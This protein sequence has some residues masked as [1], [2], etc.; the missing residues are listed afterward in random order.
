[1]Q[2]LLTNIVSA[3]KKSYKLLNLSTTWAVYFWFFSIL[4]NPKFTIILLFIW[5]GS[6]LYFSKILVVLYIYGTLAT[7]M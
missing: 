1:M 6:Q 2:K 5:F 7:S 3:G 4:C